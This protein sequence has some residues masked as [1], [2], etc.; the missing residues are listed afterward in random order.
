V[1][2]QPVIY[3][4][5]DGVLADFVFAA[6]RYWGVAYSQDNY[7][8]GAGN[9]DFVKPFCELKRFREEDFWRLPEDFWASIEW[10]KDGRDILAAV[11]NAFGIEN[12]VIVTSPTLSPRCASG[13]LIWIANHI[14][15]YRRRF[16][17]TP[18][19]SSFA[20]IDSIL[21]DD[22]DKNVRDFH[23]AGGNA[24]C[25]PRPWNELHSERR[26]A[27]EYVSSQLKWWKDVYKVVAR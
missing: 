18:C 1:K 22:Y 25:V 23:A 15:Q 21:I 9:W 4:D 24:I 11:E 16:A 17:V 2:E 8:Y 7:P 26:T 5:M 12:T 6:H 3:L 10:T 20:H 19:K 14:P 27:L 13:K